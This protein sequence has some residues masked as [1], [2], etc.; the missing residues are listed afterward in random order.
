MT[1]EEVRKIADAERLASKALDV[2]FEAN[3][4]N[5]N[6]DTY[7]DFLKARLA[8]GEARAALY[9]AELDVDWNWRT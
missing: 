1:L 6:I 8:W 9:N 3:Q 2:A 5:A 7:T 4:L